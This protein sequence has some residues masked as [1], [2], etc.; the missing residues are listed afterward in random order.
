MLQI[1]RI[2]RDDDLIERLIKLEQLFWHRV[3]NDTPPP[4]DASASS[5]RALR[6]LYPSDQGQTLEM[7]EDKEANQTFD[8]LL[9]IREQLDNFNKLEAELKH[10]LQ[11]TVGEAS[12]AT[13]VHGKNS[14]KQSKESLSFDGKRLKAEQPELYARYQLSKPG[15]RRF[16]VQLN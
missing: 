8:A 14:W 6:Q 2:E 9:E 5:D 15:S 10:Q 7:S 3:Q 16:L 12:V 1:H 4:V 13:F 11:Q